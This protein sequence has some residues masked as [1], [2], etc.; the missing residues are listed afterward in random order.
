MKCIGTYDD[1]IGMTNEL[2]EFAS[3]Q[4]DIYED[5]MCFI[6]I[7]DLESVLGKGYGRVGQNIFYGG[8]HIP[9]RLNLNGFNSKNIILFIHPIKI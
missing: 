9:N 3:V 5:R 7:D 6:E 2:F 4:N 1:L 8:D